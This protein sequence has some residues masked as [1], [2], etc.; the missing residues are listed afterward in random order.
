M[1]ERGAR[2]DDRL[3]PGLWNPRAR[4]VLPSRMAELQC[5]A[6]R[7]AGV[8][9]S[10]IR[11]L[12]HLRWE[13]AM[14]RNT[15][16]RSLGIAGILVLGSIVIGCAQQQT[17]PSTSGTSTPPPS[18]AATAPVAPVTGNYAM[19]GTPATG[20]PNHCACAPFYGRTVSARP[21]LVA[22]NSP[23]R[24]RRRIRLEFRLRI[25]RGRQACLIGR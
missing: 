3:L 11:R 12:R 23:P 13:D 14:Q 6:A 9:G 17:A 20:V 7:K 22:P 16:H 5:R 24:H 8:F 19:C 21:T 2:S 25:L 4:T 1:L 10:A 15:V 18:P